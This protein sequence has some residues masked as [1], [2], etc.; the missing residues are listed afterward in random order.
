MECSARLHLNL[1]EDQ[2]LLFRGRNHCRSSYSDILDQ[3]LCFQTSMIC[4]FAECSACL[5]AWNLMCRARN[6]IS[7]R[8]DHISW[9]QDA[10]HI[11]FAHQKN[12]QDGS[13]S[14]DPS[15]V[16][17]NTVMPEVCP[18]WELGLFFLSSGSIPM[19]WFLMAVDNR[20]VSEGCLRNYSREKKGKS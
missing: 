10:L 3:F 15:H 19:V 17:C 7:V 14:R 2:D 6:V 18:I 8:Y 5:L 9:A 11:F 16:Y 1:T 12:D 13:T 4:S 20:I